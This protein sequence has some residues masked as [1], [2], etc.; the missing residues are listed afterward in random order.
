MSPTNRRR[1]TNLHREEFLRR[2]PAWKDRIE[3][4]PAPKFKTTTANGLTKAVIAFLEY[5]GH[6]AERI[7][8]TGVWVRER[9]HVNGGY[10]RPTTGT[11][12]S[13]DVSATINGKSVKLEIKAGS[14]RQSKVQRLYQ[15][16][17][18][19]AGGVYLIV[20][21]FDEFV[22]WYDTFITGETNTNNIKP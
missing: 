20:R 11:R 1:M 7:N 15:E 2:T 10:Y 5:N 3:Q 6:Q 17:I 16:K 4:I 9:A 18:E 19:R 21:D 14:D 12:G 22:E 8:T 13:A